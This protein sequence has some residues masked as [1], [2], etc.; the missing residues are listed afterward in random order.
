MRQIPFRLWVLAAVSGLLQVV[1][2]PI[3]GPVSHW[4]SGLVFFVLVP[5]LVALL[6]CDR[7]NRPLDWRQTAALGYLSGVVWYLGNCYWIYPTMHTYGGLASPVAFGILILF[8]LYLGLYHALFGLLV[9][10]VRGSSV[11][12]AGAIVVA[13]FLW[14][15]VELARARITGFPW[16]LL[17]TAQ[18]DNFLLTQLAPFTGTYGLSF[19]IVLVNAHIAAYFV[20][21]N[22]GVR[23]QSLAIGLMLAF[24]IEL[25]G[26]H[27]HRFMPMVAN[28]Q[29]TATLLQENLEVGAQADGLALT[30][31]FNSVDAMY[32]EFDRLSLHP[33][34]PFVERRA[35][36]LI[37]PTQI[38]VWPESPAPFEAGEPRFQR[39][40]GALAATAQVPVIAGAIGVD[41]DATRL[42]GYRI[43]NSA[44]F[45]NAD[46]SSAGRY[47]K[48]HLVPWGE[49]VPFK[50]LFFFAGNL[51]Q[52][53]G[54]FDRGTERKVFR[55]GGHTYGTF[56][57]YESIF[58]NEIRQ[59]VLNGAE[60]LV[61]IS[62]D[63]W[64]GDTAAPWQHLN[65]VRMRAIENHRWILRATNTGIT[66]V[67]DP[68]GRIRERAPRHVRTAIAVGFNY[69]SEITFYTRHGVWFA[70]GCAL[71]TL[72]LAIFAILR[73]HQP[74]EDEE[75]LDGRGWR[76][77]SSGRRPAVTE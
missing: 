29:Q 32:A 41:P 73:V 47:D 1:P 70:W 46:G 30:S 27:V 40:M 2:F 61:N 60:V 48:I 50:Q 52:E 11:R 3:A 66:T 22:R 64:Y 10:L 18:V 39:Q 56:I 19:F 8:C 5:L 63:G 43:F 15:A 20:F 6:D 34:D 12:A 44:S 71:I 35:A 26:L 37:G 45:F 28:P 74:K 25:G 31:G 54:D 72:L 65:M 33:A 75:E 13:P 62:N 53:V 36:G 76:A 69:E 59:F 55:A 38:I 16:D 77:K 21:R 49:Y 9:G 42:R 68:F 4:R 67:I 14:V 51:T 17:G 23:L 57:C 24:F 7:Q 58:P